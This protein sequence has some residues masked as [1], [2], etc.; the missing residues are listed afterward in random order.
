MNIKFHCFLDKYIKN[1][2]IRKTFYFDSS[3]NSLEC[4]CFKTLGVMILLQV[5]V[6]KTLKKFVGIIL[7][8]FRVTCQQEFI[9]YFRVKFR[10][11]FLI[12]FRVTCRQEFI[13]YFSVTCRPE[14]LIYFR[15]TCRLV[16]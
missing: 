1:F 14:F 12:Y 4:R 6:G 8:Y 10:S 13:I 15:V 16:F 2:N 3:A 5:Q 7:I 11:E 9:I